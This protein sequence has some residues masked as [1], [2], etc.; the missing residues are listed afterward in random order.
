MSEIRDYRIVAKVKN[1]RIASRI[2]A[3]GYTSIAKFCDANKLH[4]SEVYPL[5][6]MKEPALTPRR[7][8]WTKAAR[9][10]AIALGVEPED[11]FNARQKTGNVGNT[12]IIREVDEETLSLDSP[13]V[14]ALPAPDA[15]GQVE[16]R[17]LITQLMDAAKLNPRSR[18]VVTA[19]YGLDG[20]PMNT[21]EIGD[22]FNVTRS[23]V[24]QIL[25]RAEDRMRLAGVRNGIKSRIK[26]NAWRWA[27]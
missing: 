21:Q 18:R 27:Y 14:A 2:E 8:E 26:P 7:G 11:L 10:L 17:V 4:Y 5:V 24:A 19:Y 25:E 16:S 12:L 22:E 15:A 23:R 9:N 1:N 20:E 6:S 3:A 13:S